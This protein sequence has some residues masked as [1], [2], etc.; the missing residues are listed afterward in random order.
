MCHE[1][2]AKHTKEHVNSKVKII[3]DKTMAKQKPNRKPIVYKTQHDQ[4]TSIIG[5]C[6]Q[7]MIPPI[8]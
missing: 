5:C 4:L 6:N 3:N 1:R 2:E 8:F 7:F